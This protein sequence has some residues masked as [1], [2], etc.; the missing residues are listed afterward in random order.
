DF[1]YGV[2]LNPPD[3]EEVSEK[4]SKSFT[5]VSNSQNITETPS[6]QTQVSPT[7]YYGVCPPW[8][9]VLARSERAHVFTD[10]KDALQAVKTMKGARFKA[11]SIRE[12]AEKFARGICD[13][14]LSPSKTVSCVSPAKPGTVLSKGGYICLGLFSFH[15]LLVL[16]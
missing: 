10:R 4:S 7:L 12:D 8:H 14:F 5:E 3:E 15:S 13:Y 1:G 2:G 16:Y 6:K 9:D 11:F